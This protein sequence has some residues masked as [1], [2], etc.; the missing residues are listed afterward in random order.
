MAK[1]DAEIIGPEIKVRTLGAAMERNPWPAPSTRY[2]D[3]ILAGA[4]KVHMPKGYQRYLEF[5]LTYKP[6]ESHRGKV[7]ASIFLKL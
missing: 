5:I 1:Q 4:L 7:G 6:P 3:I 2:M